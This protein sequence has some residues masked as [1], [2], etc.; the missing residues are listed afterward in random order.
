MRAKLL[1]IKEELRRR[2]HTPVAEVGRW[3][4]TVVVGWYRYYA[5]SLSMDCL[6]SFWYQ[7]VWLWKRSLGRRSQKGY[8]TWARR[9]TGVLQTP[10]TGI[11]AVAGVACW[12]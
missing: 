4:Q 9:L 6:R 7:V 1:E 12:C 10:I 5:V 8:L 11:E 2:R 3:V